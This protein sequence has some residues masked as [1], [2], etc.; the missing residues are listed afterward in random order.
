MCLTEGLFL[1]KSSQNWS[2]SY[3]RIFHLYINAA[4]L[5]DISLFETLPNSTTNKCFNDSLMTNTPS[6]AAAK[7]TFLSMNHSKR[8]L[9]ILQYKVHPCTSC[10]L[11]HQQEI[12]LRYYLYY[13]TF[14]LEKTGKNP[15]V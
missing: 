1:P 2:M 10:M 7:A 4:V 8:Y 13:L 12:H 3:T 15:G 11:K 9:N 5:R 6:Y 14:G